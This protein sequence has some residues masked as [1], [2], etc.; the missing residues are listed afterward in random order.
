MYTFR[1]WW[2]LHGLRVGL[3][4][5]ALASAWLVR[6]TN[7]MPVLEVYRWMQQVVRAAPS[8]AE[9]LE[10]AR[11]QELQ[12]Q[13]QEVEQQNEQLRS[14]LD[15]PDLAPVD[16]VFAPVIGRSTDQWWHQL[17]LGE[18]E[19]AGIR[20]GDMVAGT[21][22]LVGRVTQ[23]TPSTSRVLLLSDPASQVGV[24]VS[25]SRAMGYLRGQAGGQ[26]VMVLF[27]KVPDVTPGDVVTTSRLSHLFPAGIPVGTVRSIDLTKSPAPEAII[28]IS[29][30]ISRLEWVTVYANSK[31]EPGASAGFLERGRP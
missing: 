28:A 7:G 11:V 12:S 26:A 1:R 20:E 8:D 6:Q 4:T 31:L 14:L 27:D 10:S 15:S 5:L 2:E 18:G 3:I 9:A 22:G 25:R 24:T 17:L 29:A 19:S 30:P 13:L 23:V 16:K 21:G